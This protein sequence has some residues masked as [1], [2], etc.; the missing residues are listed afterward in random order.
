MRISP[1]TM[2]GS[3]DHSVLV[4]TEPS[5]K[6]FDNKN[7]INTIS[8]G[9]GSNSTLNSKDKFISPKQL[10]NWPQN[11]RSGFQTGKNTVMAHHNNELKQNKSI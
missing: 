9:F 1:R 11:T 6:L 7:G 4:L 5:K 8:Y 2:E 3:I 10:K